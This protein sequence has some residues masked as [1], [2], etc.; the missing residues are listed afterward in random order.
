MKFKALF[1]LF[2]FS[3]ILSQDRS[4]I[5]TTYTGD[6]PDP[7]AGGY[8]IQHLDGTEENQIYG[9]ANKFFISLSIASYDALSSSNFLFASLILSCSLF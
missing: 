1:T 2:I 9:A 3:L 6:N 8:S 5:F 7:N 4:T